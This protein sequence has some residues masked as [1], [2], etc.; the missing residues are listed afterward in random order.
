MDFIK[1]YGL[2]AA[3]I[4]LAL[5]LIAFGSAK[6]FG[7]PQFHESFKALGLP[8]WFG[9]FI[10]ACEVAGAVGLFIKPLRTLAAGGIGAIL[11]GALYFHATHPPAAAGVPALILLLLAGCIVTRNKARLVSA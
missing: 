11:V 1:K 9:Y 2:L 5:P 6:L 8:G 7:V 4:L 10:G 3:C